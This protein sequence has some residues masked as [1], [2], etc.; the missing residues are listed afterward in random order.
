M[1]IIPQTTLFS[2][3][4]D[5]EN[6]GDLIRLQRVLQYL[7]DEALM[8]KLEQ[9]RGKGRDRY[10]VRAM[11]NALIAMIVFGHTSYA[12]L[13]RELSRNVQ[14][15][16]LC[17]FDQGPVPGSD[18]MSQ[19]VAKLQAHE[20]EILELFCRLSQALYDLLPDFGEALALD[21]KWV[22]SK[23]NRQ[24]SKKHPDGRSETDAAWGRKDYSGV[25]EDGTT[26]SKTVS[27]FGFKTH[28]WVDAKYELPV[29]FF[30]TDAAASDVATGEKMLK[31]LKQERPEILNRCRYWMADKG[32][33][34][35][36][37]LLALK[38]AGIKAIIDKR[39]M[40]RTQTE[41]EVP[42]YEGM[43]YSEA[44]EVFCYGKETGERHSMQPAGYEKERDSLRK[45]CPVG[46]YGAS[47]READTCPYC[48]NI[49][50]PLETDPRIFT[51]VDRTSYKWKRLYAKRTAVERVNSRLDVSFGFETR[52]IRGMKTMNLLTALA[53]A[54]M[55][56]LAVVSIQENKKERMRSLV[57]AA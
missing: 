52:R 16:F 30:N 40:W 32:Y 54:I 41:K 1:A 23:A 51:Q 18:N 7:P 33:D 25:R 45:R 39:T 12:S 36:D 50:I 53:F 43:Y 34:D 42:G 24:S 15:R 47:C 2:W 35:T 57:R 31:R 27:C 29:Y 38:D 4:N 14:L 56:S 28:I 11:W 44:G 10:P 5:I 26:W 17:G 49:R 48:K 9:E 21:S 8:Q 22:W 37:F 19:F 6:L 20:T 3:E 46:R 13:L 55:D